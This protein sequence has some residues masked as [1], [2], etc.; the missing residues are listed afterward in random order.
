MHNGPHVQTLVRLAVF[1]AVVSACGGDELGLPPSHTDAGV[2]AT[3]DAALGPRARFATFNTHR[4]FDTVCDSGDCASGSYEDLPTPAEF[5]AKAV[6]LAA[7]IRALGAD[8]VMLEEVETQPCLDALVSRLGDVLP[9]GELGETGAPASVDV[10]ILSAVPIESVVRHRAQQLKRPD[11]STTIF[12]RELLEVH[13]TLHGTR[14]IAFAAHF[15]SKVSDDPG[16]RL[17]E[18]QASH[19]IIV[20]AARAAPDALVVLGGDLN[21]MPGSPPIDALEDDGLLLRVA[22]ELAPQDQGTF[23]YQGAWQAIDHLFQAREG[24]GVYVNGSAHA[25]RGNPGYAGSD[26]AALVADFAL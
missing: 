11:G 24:A 26:H 25:V 6:Q 18:A 20:A 12:S 21:D 22:R 13:L 1:V 9:Y 5:A 2:D 17:A 4:F 10:A 16:R 3:S 14:V 19:D 15:R 23:V 7:G 8:V